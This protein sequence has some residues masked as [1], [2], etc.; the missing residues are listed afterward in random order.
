MNRISWNGFWPPLGTTYA[1][2]WGG[3]F[4]REFAILL[5]FAATLSGIPARW[6]SDF[7]LSVFFRSPKEAWKASWFA[8]SKLRAEEPAKLEFN[9]DIRPILS[10]TCFACHGF[11]EK[12]RQG[13]LR[14]DTLDGAIADLGGHAA[15][16]PGDV[17]ASEI[18]A[19]IHSTDPDLVMPPPS[20]KKVLTDDQKQKLKTWIEQG[21]PYQSH[22]AFEPLGQAQPPAGEQWSSHPIDRFLLQQMQQRGLQPQAEADRYTLIRRVAFTLTGLPPTAVEVQAFVEDRSPYAYEDMVERYLASKRYGEEMAKHWLDVARYA[23][24]HGLHLD[25]ERAMWAYRD[26]VIESFNK[27]QPF[28][29]FTIEQI[30]GDLLP[31]PSQDQLV[32]TGFN[33]CNVTTS[34]GGAITEEF[35]FRYAVERASTT[36]QTWMGMTG[37]CAVCHSHK[38]DPLSMKEFYS[39]YAFFYSA[40]DPAMDGNNNITPPLLKLSNPQRDSEIARWKKLEVD[41][42]AALQRWMDAG[43]YQDP[44]SLAE[45]PA[46]TQGRDLWLDDRFP[47][48]ASVSCSSRN[49]STWISEEEGLKPAS[50]LRALKQ[51]SAVNYEDRID[52][53]NQPWIVP[54]DGKLHLQIRV[55]PK[56]VPE[57]LML[58]IA[59]TA[60][61]RKLL[62]GNVDRYGGV[63]QTNRIRVGDVP[64][65]GDWTEVVFDATKWSLPAGTLVNNLKLAQYGGEAYWDKIE[66]EGTREPASDVRASLIAWWDSRKGKETR[67]VGGNLNKILKEGRQADSTP[68]NQTALRN[69]FLQ[70]V[71]RPVN[72]EHEKLLASVKEAKDYLAWLEEN[73]PATFV[74]AD[75]GSPRQ[76]SMMER[77][78]YD[79]PGEKVEPGT[80]AFLPPLKGVDGRRASRLDLAR[81]LVSEEH[82]LTSRVTVNRFW[83]QVFGTGLV[84]TSYDFGSQ[85]EVPSHPELLDWLA[86]WYQAND[87][88]TKALMRL[89]LLSSAFKQ[90]GVTTPTLLAADAENR[91]LARGPRLR[92]D[93]EQIRDSALFVSGLMDFT[94]GG[95]GFK[96]YQPPNIW[97]PV[98]YADSNTRFYLQDHGNK[99]YRRS[100]YAFFKRTAPPPFMS[101][102]DAP[103]RE[104]FCTMRERS[105]TPLQALQLMNDVQHFEAARAF[106]ERM[107]REGGTN[108]EDRILFAYK[109]ALSR[110]P[111]ENEQKVLRATLQ[112]FLERYQADPAA[113]EAVVKNG[114]SEAAPQLDKRELAAYTL[115]GNL[116]LNLDETIHRN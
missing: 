108:A 66:M 58:E 34:E 20:T 68:E 98:G 116:I 7:C 50:G 27:N 32:A 42:V 104:Q 91:Y 53:P 15:I 90:Q 61:G 63:D 48:G 26:W 17:G 40:A 38:Y 106:G 96:T 62:W 111:R 113:A 31:N 112:K 11:D 74:F 44:A 93:A 59:T 6:A 67:G 8:E 92:L 5:I 94:M 95:P 36:I 25:N 81:W 102:F 110:E 4:P 79:K 54:A 49:P 35:L 52:Q 29:Q 2:A 99:L 57:A 55:D 64:A 85:G 1:N 88:D 56:S 14:L 60:G 100:V 19:R 78:Q 37:G 69:H 109:V 75:L 77:G 83:Q 82:P 43:L 39:F 10:E 33:R 18:W 22:W 84:K 45:K 9:R 107:L 16:K 70:S 3:R 41:R 71:A 30:A 80:P 97:E 24:T 28:D 51:V 103:N 47:E 101:N 23:D 12:K 65:S 73:R 115:L 21:A 87:W 76:A 13:H 86:R 72:S 114:E 46:A 105:N 89:L